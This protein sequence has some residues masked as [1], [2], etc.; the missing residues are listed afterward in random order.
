MNNLDKFLSFIPKNISF[1]DI[2]NLLVSDQ[3]ILRPLRGLAFE[4]LVDDIFSKHF[5]IKLIPGSGDSDV[6]RFFF[7][8]NKKISIQIKTP[9]INLTKDNKS[10]SFALH[11]THGLEK[12]PQNLYPIKFPCPICEHDGES[13]PDFLIAKHPTKGVYIIPKN[14]ISENKKY[15]GHFADPFVLD[16]NDKKLNKWSELGFEN[17]DN[18]NL[19]RS[20][21]KKQDKFKKVSELI[22][23]SDDE[24]ISLF[25]KPENFRLF[26]M[27]LLGNLREPALKKFLFTKKVK[28][29]DPNIAY[30]PYDL[31]VKNK[32]IQIKGISQHLCRDNIIGT[33]VMGTHGKNAIRRYSKKD[34]DYLCLVLDPRYLVK[35]GQTDNKYNFIFIKSDELPDHP[36]NEEWGTNDKIYEN[37]KLEV[38]KKSETLFFI[39]ANNYRI[40][41]NFKFKEIEM[42]KIPNEFI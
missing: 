28:Y 33:E 29:E 17:F 42:N 21:I 2:D 32:K 10:V 41:L 18:Q 5:K 34:F 15:P 36:R 38:L 16:W 23:L 4:Y 26:R 39:P 1:D 24:I 37:I 3:N 6:D 12:K 22:K 27:N 11:K 30:P 13:F 19:L 31:V 7:L 40:K 35:F 25:L 8:K 20:D 14:E 9:V